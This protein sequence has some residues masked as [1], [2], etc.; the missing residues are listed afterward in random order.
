MRPQVLIWWH[1]RF[2]AC[3]VFGE[4]CEGNTKFKSFFPHCFE[5]LCVPFFGNAKPHRL[6]SLDQVPFI[7]LLSL[8]PCS[9]RAIYRFQTITEIPQHPPPSSSPQRLIS[10]FAILPFFLVSFLAVNCFNGDNSS[11]REVWGGWGK[12]YSVETMP[13]PAGNCSANGCGG[14]SPVHTVGEVLITEKIM[15]DCSGY[16]LSSYLFHLNNLQWL[17]GVTKW[18][19]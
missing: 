18:N 10:S 7:F 12:E 15:S 14:R 6:L 17:I 11:G 9:G 8:L 1:C 4:K 16:C 5:L 3:Q 2:E 19:F 13:H